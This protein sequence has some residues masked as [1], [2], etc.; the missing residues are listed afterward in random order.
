[1][2]SSN[3][4]SPSRPWFGLI[5]SG[6][7]SVA[8]A[9]MALIGILALAMTA[10]GWWAMRSQTQSLQDARIQ[11]LHAAG[12]VLADSAESLVL[13]EE[14]SALRRLVMYSAQQHQLDLC[15]VVMPDGGV[16][17]DGDPS[18][19][20]VTTLPG[21]WD[22]G[23]QGAP[24]FDRHGQHVSMRYP[25][26]VPGRGGLVLEITGGPRVIDE[27]WATEAGIGAIGVVALIVLLLIYRHMR[28]QVRPLAAISE[29][30]Q[31]IE[32]G[33][34]T[35]AALTVSPS[36][37]RLAVTWNN[38]L[39]ERRGKWTQR[40]KEEAK[41]AIESRRAPSGGLTDACN[42]LSQGLLLVD[43]QQRIA[44]ANG[45]AA[46][47]LGGKRSDLVGSEWGELKVDDMVTEAVVRAASGGERQRCTLEVDRND[48]GGDGVLRFSIRPITRG[49]AP[50]AVVIIDDITQLRVAEHSRNTFIAQATHELRMPLTNIRLYI[51]TALESGDDD[52][53]LRG[54]C[55]NVINSE[56]RRLEGL[57]SNM[58]S[59]SE[60][61]A[62]SMSLQLGDV[63][64]D[65]LFEELENDFRAKAN[66]KSIEMLFNLPPKLPVVQGDRERL[67][68]AFQNLLGNALKYTPEHGKVEVAVEASAE[69]LTVEVKDSGIGIDQKDLGHIFD[70]FYRADDKRVREISGSGLGLALSREVVRL[71][72]GDITAESELDRGTAFT[73]TLP[74]TVE[75]V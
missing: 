43:E 75:A 61:E 13:A 26:F 41:A 39:D 25:L 53:E 67:V 74:I 21:V 37:G 52:A 32:H 36:F 69:L 20:T 35:T 7:S 62:G 64:L 38:V 33:E 71:H 23:E 56:S 57:V 27:V 42:A 3:H 17:A 4:Q 44:Y 65:A 8:P 59:I 51:E 48:I 18:R 5:P 70:R 22:A 14:V 16:L 60:I 54:Q 47:F 29:S 19:I 73:M 72:G 10:A 24:A 49:D 58:L 50:A 46:V 15:R 9:G 31:A 28:S 1:M 12:G 55:L 45:A 68:I 63:R 6:E 30:L 66:E 40:V 2:S 11:E 34:S